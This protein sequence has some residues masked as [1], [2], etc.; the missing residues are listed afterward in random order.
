MTAIKAR[1]PVGIGE[2]MAAAI[3]HAVE[4][5]SD[6]EIGDLQNI[7]QG[8]VD[9]MTPGQR[10]QHLASLPVSLLHRTEP[11]HKWEAVWT[12]HISDAD[13][14]AFYRLAAASAWALLNPAQT[15]VALCKDEV[16]TVLELGGFNEWDRLEFPTDDEIKSVLDGGW[17]LFK[18]ADVPEKAGLGPLIPSVRRALLATIARFDVGEPDL[19]EGPS[20][21]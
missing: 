10:R 20:G 7:V 8:A 18:N 19:E 6:H 14:L 9:V 2:L 11:P 13:E 17:N 3:K 15:K 4:E 1:L 16:L 12:G 21:I 5:G